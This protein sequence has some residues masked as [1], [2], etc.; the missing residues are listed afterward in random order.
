MEPW[1]KSLYQT[2]RPVTCQ[3]NFCCFSHTEWKFKS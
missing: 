2:F 3:R 1:L